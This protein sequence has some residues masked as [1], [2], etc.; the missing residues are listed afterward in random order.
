MTTTAEKRALVGASKR[1]ALAEPPPPGERAEDEVSGAALTAV[2]DRY[3]A[4]MDD[5]LKA[6]SAP[7]TLKFGQVKDI[8]VNRVGRWMLV[9]VKFKAKKGQPNEF[10]FRIGRPWAGVLYDRLGRVLP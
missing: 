4:T 7:A 2:M 5:D 1:V 10:T 9:T 8:R 3:F 6:A